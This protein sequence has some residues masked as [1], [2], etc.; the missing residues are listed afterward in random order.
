MSLKPCEADLHSEDHETWGKAIGKCSSGAPW[1]CAEQKVCVYDGVCFT[2]PWTDPEKALAKITELEEEI[3]NLKMRE[4][5]M[6]SRLKGNFLM[7][8]DKYQNALKTDNQPMVWATEFVKREIKEIM[9]SFEI[10]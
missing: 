5:L 4:T 7:M 2:N 1:V 8:T 10:V 6:V 9:K 3:S